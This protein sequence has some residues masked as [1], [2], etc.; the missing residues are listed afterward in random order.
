MP[1]GRP[2]CR[3][4]QGREYASPGEACARCE[5]IGAQAEDWLALKCENLHRDEGNAQ[6]SHAVLFGAACLLVTGFN[7]G[8]PGAFPYLQE[9]A[10]R[11]D[12]PWSERELRHKLR[13]AG[14][15]GGE[16]GKLIWKRWVRDG[17]GTTDGTEGHRWGSGNSAGASST[18]LMDEPREVRKNRL[19]FDLGTLQAAQAGVVVDREWLQAR[20]VCRLD[21]VTPEFF[22]SA[23]YPAGSRVL[24]FTKFQSQG[25]Y[26][27]QVPGGNEPGWDGAW[28][29]GRTRQEPAVRAEG[30]PRAG[31]CGVWFLNQPVDG[32]WREK[33]GSARW[34]KAGPEFS[35]RHE[36]C[37]QGWPYLVLESDIKGIEPLWL[38]FLAGVPLPI[39]ALYTSGGKSVHALVRVDAPTKAAWDKLRE[40]LKPWLT[41]HGADPGVFSAVRLTRLPGCLRHGTEKRA[42]AGGS[43]GHGKQEMIYERYGQPRPQ[44]LLYFNPQADGRAMTVL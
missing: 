34:G 1:K 27:W 21:T 2:S 28:R 20:S 41:K 5:D 32:K 11:S 17:G 35:R 40:E 10:R 19:D 42:P 13:E 7:L 14:K 6:D 31:S 39:V 3:A 23:L 33:P 24:V 18:A 15:V 38:N 4:C 36:P 30:L 8:E 16:A 44:E 26:L 22:L 9:Y 37:V 12:S 25:Q 29:L 43:G